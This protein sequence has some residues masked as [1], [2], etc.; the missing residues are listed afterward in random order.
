MNKIERIQY[1]ALQVSFLHND[2]N[3]DCNTLLTKS[4]KCSMEVRRLRT[5]AL[6][7]FKSPNTILTLHSLKNYLTKETDE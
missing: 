2:Y 7:I 4:G 6:E 3:P 5:M 1:R